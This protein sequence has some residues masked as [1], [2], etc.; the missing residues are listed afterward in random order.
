MTIKLTRLEIQAALWA[1][2]QHCYRRGSSRVNKRKRTPIPLLG[3][4]MAIFNSVPTREHK[5]ALAKLRSDI[6]DKVYGA[7]FKTHERL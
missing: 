1:V 5:D 3:L 4:Q 6:A 2:G 7:S